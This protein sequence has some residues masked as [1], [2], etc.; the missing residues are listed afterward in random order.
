[1]CVVISLGKVSASAISSNLWAQLR[2]PW[3]ASSALA[4]RLRAAVIQVRRLWPRIYKGGC[5]VPPQSGSVSACLGKATTS[6]GGSRYS[7]DGKHAERDGCEVSRE[8]ACV[9]AAN[10]F[11]I[12]I[13]ASRQPD[14]YSC[15]GANRRSGL[16]G[17]GHTDG[18][19]GSLPR[20]DMVQPPLGMTASADPGFPVAAKRQHTL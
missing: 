10:G 18:D 9:S 12:P 1:M 17:A 20:L 8:R 15:G 7:G 19:G 11:T 3:Q 6:P 14:R 2:P 4:L 13:L 16:C 5:H